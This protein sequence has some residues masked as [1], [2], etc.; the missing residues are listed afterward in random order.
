MLI[1]SFLQL[2]SSAKLRAFFILSNLYTY[3]TF[4]YKYCLISV[5]N[6]F[7]VLSWLNICK[8]VTKISLRL[9]SS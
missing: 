9:S 4:S 3:L 2:R 5:V 1:I 7:D 8:S 6:V